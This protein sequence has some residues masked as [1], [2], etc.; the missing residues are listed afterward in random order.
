MRTEQQ[1]AVVSR[2][3]PIDVRLEEHSRRCPEVVGD[4]SG[5][6][7]ASYRHLSEQN[8]CYVGDLNLRRWGAI[9]K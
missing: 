8:R 4:A 7:Q 9:V 1:G 3:R 6:R 2:T 5:P